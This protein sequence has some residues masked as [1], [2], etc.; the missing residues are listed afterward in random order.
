M[1]VTMAHESDSTFYVWG[2]LADLPEPLN[3]AKTFFWRALDRQVLTVPG[4]FFDVNPGKRRHG[5]SPY[6]QWMRFS[7][8]PPMDNMVLGL[9]RL[10]EMVSEAR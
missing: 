9:E 2:C 6:E 10:A 1:G 3:D 5:P 7:F 4:E 8:G